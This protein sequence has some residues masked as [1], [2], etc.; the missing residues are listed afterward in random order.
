[1]NAPN[2]L[3]SM[4]T[5][6][7]FDRIT[8]ELI[9]DA[10]PTLISQAQ[11]EI[12]AIKAVEGPRTWANTMRALEYASSGLDD[13]WGVAQHL[14]S[15]RSTEE[16][17]A[18]VMELM[19]SVTAF[20]TGASLDEELYAALK[21]YAATDEAAALD[22]VRARLLR[23]TLDGFRRSGADLPAS[24]RPEYKALVERLALATQTFQNNV[25][26]VTAAWHLDVPLERLAG[27]PETS[28]APM[29]AVAKAA[30]VEGAR[31]RLIAPDVVG[32]MTHAEDRA[33]RETI[34]KAYNSRASTGEHDNSALIDEILSLRAR[35]AT[36]LGY[37]DFSDY[38]LEPRMA[39]SGAAAKAFED[40]LEG[41][42]RDAA[43]AEHAAL[44]A[45][46][47]EQ[48]GPTPLEGWD[49]N[50]WSERLRKARYDLDPEVVRQYFSFESVLE[51]AFSVAR[52]LYG[53]EIEP[54]D[55][56]SWHPD[57]QTYQ[58]RDGDRVLGVFHA[59][60]FPRSD[61]RQGAWM[62]SLKFGD[63]ETGHTPHVGLICGNLTPAS[64]DKP[65]LLTHR[66][67]ETV[68]HE[69][70][71]LLH[72]M[73]SDVKYPSIAGTNVAW[74][75]VELPSQIMENWC[76]EK[77]AL[78]TFAK[79][80]ETGEPLPQDLFDRMFAA[81]TFR[82][83]TGQ[84]RQLCFGQL[85]L[86]LHREFTAGGDTRAVDAGREIAQNYSY[87]ELPS[88]YSMLTAFGHLFSGPVAYASGYYSYKWAEVLDADAFSRF[89]K[90]GI[91]S[92]ETGKAFRD[93][94][95][96]RGAEEEPAS[97]FRAFMGRDPSPEA[98]FERLGLN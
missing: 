97:L 43:A 17:Q 72:H 16:L 6:I 10:V 94:L 20:Y 35:Q 61:K 89:L 23:K 1:M 56:P 95:L 63:R 31:I 11:A 49:V 93:T 90:E 71:H 9:R 21:A 24:D 62:N 40:Q 46:V 8:P 54:T 29:V 19:P 59:D 82:A 78:D 83:A 77:E 36:M 55:I 26:A 37:A 15:V 85:D 2:P 44:Q 47:T 3:L 69:F 76:W 52:T 92:A 68:F 65:S 74:D 45:F 18:A 50:F 7:P 48:G 5:A 38:V 14:A 25:L 51:G 88:D 39:G 58:I 80:Y 84:L 98:L 60:F 81:K 30:G 28:V 12:D 75:F 73:L 64:G 79:H 66:E 13:A 57:V 4:S 41:R 34:W 22:P 91:F 42:T 27:V 96:S 86:F 32:I 87:V 67:V 53:V 70:G 33:L